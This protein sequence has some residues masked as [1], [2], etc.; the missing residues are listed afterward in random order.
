MSI[1]GTF[2]LAI[3]ILAFALTWIQHAWVHGA[4]PI[5]MPFD[6]TMPASWTF[7]F[8]LALGVCAGIHVAVRAFSGEVPKLIAR[9]TQAFPF[10]LAFALALGEGIQVAPVISMLRLVLPRWF[11]LVPPRFTMIPPWLLI[12]LA[13]IH[14][15]SPCFAGQF[16]ET[17]LLRIFANTSMQFIKHFVTY[18]VII[19]AASFTFEQFKLLSLA[20]H[21]L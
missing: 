8:A 20:I 18:L 12:Q 17:P 7:A 16:L 4:V 15:V 6:T 9:V 14:G 11:L 1:I 2:A 13:H 3:G 21:G 19:L 5:N 10:A